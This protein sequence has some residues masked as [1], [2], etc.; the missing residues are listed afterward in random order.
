MGP[1]AGREAGP[2]QNLT[3]GTPEVRTTWAHRAGRPDGQSDGHPP[4]DRATTTVAL[5]GEGEDTAQET[6]GRMC[7]TRSQSPACEHRC[8]EIPQTEMGTGDTAGRGV[9]GGRQEGGFTELS[10][11]H[12]SARNGGDVARSAKQEALRSAEGSAKQEW[13]ACL[14]PGRLQD[15]RQLW[16]GCHGQNPGC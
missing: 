14:V 4:G 16:P 7:G 10:E 12:F 1:G 5:W 6:G 3:Q 15:A 2:V 13:G 11:G 9:G 8:L